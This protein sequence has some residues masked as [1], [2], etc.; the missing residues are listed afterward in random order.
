MVLALA[1]EGYREGE[2]R[3]VGLGPPSAHFC[4]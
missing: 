4:I 2:E 3:R 1:R